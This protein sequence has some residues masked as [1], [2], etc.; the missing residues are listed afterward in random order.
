M[1]VMSG[2]AVLEAIRTR[3]STA[4]LPVIIVSTDGSAPRIARTHALGAHFVHKPFTP[5]RLAAVIVAALTGE[6]PAAP[7]AA[8]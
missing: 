2:D 5:E 3:P 1:P 8:S 6:A 7:A 4:D